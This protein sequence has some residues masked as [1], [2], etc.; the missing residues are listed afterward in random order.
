MILVDTSVWIELLA[1][2][3]GTTL[4]EE[5]LLRFVTCGPIVQEVLQGLRPGLESDAL[6]QAFLAIPVLSDPV[7]LG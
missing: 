2:R 4:S 1:G 5:D 3:R 7:P 6:R